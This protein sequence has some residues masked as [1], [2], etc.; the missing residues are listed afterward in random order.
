MHRTLDPT[1]ASRS[2]ARAEWHAAAVE[3]HDETVRRQADSFAAMLERLRASAATTAATIRAEAA[4]AGIDPMRWKH[5]TVES[6]RAMAARLRA[7]ARRRAV[8]VARRPAA[9]PRSPHRH[10]RAHRRQASRRARGPDD[11]ADPDEPPPPHARTEPR[12]ELALGGA[13]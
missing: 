2:A 5:L 10:R 8:L 9:R 11:G 12:I 6:F 1:I 3:L 7:E 4:A 13:P